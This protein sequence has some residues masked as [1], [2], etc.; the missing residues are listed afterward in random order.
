M[1]QTPRAGLKGNAL[2]LGRTTISL[3]LNSLA[4]WLCHSAVS[5]TKSHDQRCLA[6][7]RYQSQ[8][9][10]F[11]MT[12][13]TRRERGQLR[14]LS[15][16][17][18]ERELSHELSHLEEQFTEWREGEIDSF[19]LSDIIHEFHDGVSRELYK[20]YMNVSPHLMVAYALVESILSEEEIQPELLK[21]LAQA[22]ELYRFDRGEDREIE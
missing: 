21:K 7:G 19:E 4:E 17:A 8:K 11:Q 1:E 18:Y 5:G 16:K 2:E 13:F 20:E 12:K 10:I 15:M 6:R 3:S 22:I 14:K 9:I